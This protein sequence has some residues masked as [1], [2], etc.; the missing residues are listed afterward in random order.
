MKILE[1]ESGGGGLLAR[2]SIS[3]GIVIAVSKL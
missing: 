1:T 2:L 3:L